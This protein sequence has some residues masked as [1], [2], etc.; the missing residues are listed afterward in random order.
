MFILSCLFF[1]NVLQAQQPTSP[2]IAILPFTA[3]GVD[4]ATLASAEQ[5]LRMEITRL[6]ETPIVAEDQ[7]LAQYPDEG[8]VDIP[9]A[10]EVGKALNASRVIMCN[11]SAL[12]EKIIVH[13]FLIDVPAQKAILK[14]E[15]T[16]TFV[17]DLDRVMK[18][19]AASLVKEKTVEKSATVEN[20]V[21]EEALRPLRRSS[22]GLFGITFGY[23]YPESGYDRVDRSFT[24][25]VRIANEL[26]DYEI[27]M[28]FAARKGFVVNVYGNRLFSRKD[29]S[30]YLGAAIGFHWVSHEVRYYV[31]PEYEFMEED[32]REDGIEV[33][34]NG[35]I[36]LFR[37][38]NFQVIANLAFAM[39][40]NDYDDRGAIFTIGIVH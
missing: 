8:C 23:L 28:L 31:S 10:I 9:C 14:E 5:I 34:L 40:F 16:A 37:T 35:G 27:G 13:Y 21:T 22:R 6:T 29:F 30:P 2:A 18:R 15:I 12:G 32:K 39:V 19:I 1:P 24:M 20:I 38:Y 36:K 25:E 17:E 11:L 33:S 7:V 3:I 4:E 26:P